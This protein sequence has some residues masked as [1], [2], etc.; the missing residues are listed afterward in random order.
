MLRRIEELGVR[1]DRWPTLSECR[2]GLLLRRSAFQTL[3]IKDNG[4]LEVLP[5]CI[6]NTKT[7][8]LHML[9]G[10]VSMSLLSQGSERSAHFYL[11]RKISALILEDQSYACF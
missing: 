9:C 2:R 11:N 5:L 1:R 4:Y 8:L 7:L 6:T 3:G 10:L